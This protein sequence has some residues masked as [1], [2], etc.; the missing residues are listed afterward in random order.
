MKFLKSLLIVTTLLIMFFVNESN[1]QNIDYPTLKVIK[2]LAL[3]LEPYG[4][5]SPNNS[6]I[7]VGPFDNYIISA[8]VGFMEPDIC[9]NY[10]NPLNFVATDNRIITG[11]NYVYYTINGGVNWS[12]TTVPTSSGDP[13][14]ASDSLGN[15]Y[16]AYLSNGVRIQKSTNG[17][18]SWGA[19]VTI[20]SN[21]SA[22]KEWIWADRTNGPTKNNLYMAYF[23]A[24]SGSQRTDF[25]RSTNNGAS[26]IG[27]TILQ[28][29]V[30]TN[31]G[32]NIVTD[33]NG[34]VFVFITASTGA[35]VKTS[36]DGGATFSADNQAASYIE[37]GVVNAT[38]G[39]RCV[40]GNIRTNG[41]PQ[42]AADL[43]NGPYKGN[44]YISYAA[45]PPG[46]DNA[47]VYVARTTNGGVSWALPV[48][49]NDDVTTF[50]QW[51]SDVSVDDQGR[52]WVF[53]Y[54]SRNDPANLLTE[55]WAAVSTNGGASFM[56]NFKVSSQNFNPNTVKVYQ[57]TDHYYIGD[58]IGMSGRTFTSPVYCNQNNDMGN[59]FS[60][61]LPDYGV[62][63][64]KATDNLSTN[65]ISVNYIRIPMLGPYSGT[66]TYSATVT[67]APAVGSIT[68]TYQP[69]NVKVLTGTPDSL[70]ISAT[71]S[72]NCS[73]GTY[74][75]T[76]TGAENG[77]PRTHKRTYTLVVGS[78]I[79]G[80]GNNN[81]EVSQFNLYQ[82]YPNPF[83]PVTSIEYYLPK[84]TMV[85]LK[86]YDL[87]GREVAVLANNELRQAGLNQ[88]T[89]DGKELA[90]GIYYYK[91]SAGEFS[92]VKRMM[93]V[94]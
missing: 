19:A 46:P 2:P 7:S 50:D 9:V 11:A 21:A 34:K 43:S 65:N 47:N 35:V 67:P 60:A 17:G 26:W 40:K 22:D 54:D 88:V 63:F 90:S 52:V 69:S 23:N 6:I 32:P 72:G 30:S 42:A 89:F 71:T 29:T 77:G 28:A 64:Q 68:F 45:N 48:Q 8:S 49:V 66:V 16:L 38:T 57:G 12:Q 55:H 31:P 41:H 91:I 75:V 39:R 5:D 84:Q 44:V 14:F 15:L 94:K 1:S 51:M 25:F 4:M 59:D 13:V 83:N 10:T 53:W 37:P 79:S 18:V 20:V 56:P 78:T 33:H 3:T 76:V 36:S 93:L 24:T 80:T 27:P 74:T 87:V 86:V 81:G 62:S 92:D 58:Y 61:Y 82:N 85:S 73:Y 70:K